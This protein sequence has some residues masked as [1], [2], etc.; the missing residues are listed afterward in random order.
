MFSARGPNNFLKDLAIG[1]AL[2]GGL[3]AP[4]GRAEKTSPASTAPNEP[5]PNAPI[6]PEFSSKQVA[7]LDR[8]QLLEVA[9]EAYVW[10][11]PLI[12]LH[13]IKGS[14]ER[15]PYPG[16]S[17]GLPVAPINQL[18]ML[19]DT[20]KPGAAAIP[21]ANQ[22]VIYGFGIL[23]LKRE[24][25]VIQVPD[26]GDRF[27]LYQLGD[28]RT[29]AFGRMGRM[30]GTRPGCY[31]V[32]GPDW[33]QPTPAGIR[34]VVR[35]PTRCGY[36]IPRIHFENSEAD[37]IAAIPVVNQIAAYPLRC[38][39]GSIQIRS[40]DHPRWLPNLGRAGRAR[41]VS[42]DTFFSNFS[43]VLEDV[44][45]RLGEE[46]MYARFE[47]LAS[48]MRLDPD[49]AHDV[50]K[51]ARGFDQDLIQP[52]FEFR[53]VGL[54]LRGNWTTISNGGEFGSDYLT[55][56]AVAK[57]NPFVNRS[58]EAS[59]Y[60]LDL[61]AEGSVLSGEHRYEL[62]FA[63]GSL[64]PARGFWSLTVYDE[65]H[66][67]PR[68]LNGRITCGSR[69]QSL[70]F[71]TD[72]SLTI[73]VDRSAAEKGAGVTGPKQSCSNILSAPAGKFSLYLRVYEPYEP[74]EASHN[75][76]WSPPAARKCGPTE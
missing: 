53:N 9:K 41:D 32:V 25:V 2:L 35:C 27:W 61:D 36:F 23:D 16:V 14:L 48:E 40:W 12:Y 10:G 20:I 5:P 51:A 62:T 17:G 13:Q 59:Y 33:D 37:R 8:K 19:V 72:G 21:C 49:F 50:V 47:Q 60:Y 63:R 15:V 66:V 65:R 42:P 44:P 57:S 24:P 69:D 73:I 67:L 43:R 75:G 31:L 76:G 54:Q 71:N 29:D 11:W 18:S 70:A 30:Y 22:D 68:D 56:A 58:N 55:R 39:N 38:F 6:K 64:P 26:F 52:L 3:P 34:E 46:E 7:T 74:A 45:P 1:M 28:Q 4:E